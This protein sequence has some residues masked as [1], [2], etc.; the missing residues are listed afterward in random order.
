MGIISDKMN[1]FGRN[2]YLH[3]YG[4]QNTKLSK[5]HMQNIHALNSDTHKLFLS[6]LILNSRCLGVA[7]EGM[8]IWYMGLIIEYSFMR[9]KL[10]CK[11]N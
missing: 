8:D 4:I 7:I 5:A 9:H 1:T 3:E 10:C 2:S 6:I 11:L